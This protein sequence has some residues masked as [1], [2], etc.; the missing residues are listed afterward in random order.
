MK[1]D[2]R[3]LFQNL[4]GS[5]HDVLLLTNKGMHMIPISDYDEFAE[6][7]KVSYGE[8]GY[9]FKIYGCVTEYYFLFGEEKVNDYLTKREN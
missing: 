3:T 4:Q 8:D 1:T 2:Y 9:E 6:N 7:T 5:Q